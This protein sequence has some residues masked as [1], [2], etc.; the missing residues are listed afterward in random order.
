MLLDLFLPRGPK[1]PTHFKS[2]KFFSRHFHYNAS[3]SA[4]Y[5]LGDD[6]RVLLKCNPYLELYNNRKVNYNYRT[7]PTP[8]PLYTHHVSRR[9]KLVCLQINFPNETALSYLQFT[10][11]DEKKKILVICKRK[12]KKELDTIDQSLLISPGSIA[13]CGATDMKLAIRGL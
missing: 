3:S 8:T 5:V 2:T 4:L 9:A 1:A 13:W 6:T 12:K 10:W 7:P 11:R